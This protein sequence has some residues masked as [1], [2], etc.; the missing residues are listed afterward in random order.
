MQA[1]EGDENALRQLYR[2]ICCDISH[3]SIIKL[4][5]EPL[6]ERNF[7]EWHMGFVN[8]TD[9]ILNLQGFS[10]IFHRPASEHHILA[11]T[12]HVKELLRAFRK[13]AR[14]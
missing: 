11:N 7:P 3:H 1:I 8:Q 12:S 6:E 14:I 13:S 5:D 4:I 2:N 9:T 10:Y